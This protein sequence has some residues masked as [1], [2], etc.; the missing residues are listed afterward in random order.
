MKP[1]WDKGGFKMKYLKPFLHSE[2]EAR[3]SICKFCSI[4]RRRIIDGDDGATLIGDGFTPK[5]IVD[6]G[7]NHGDAAYRR[8]RNLTRHP[9]NLPLERLNH[10]DALSYI[11]RDGRITSWTQVRD[12]LAI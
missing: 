3:I 12:A 2:V 11:L 8:I 9:R 10:A 4:V 5:Q 6:G 7:I 1:P